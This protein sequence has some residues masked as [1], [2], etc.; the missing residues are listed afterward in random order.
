[1][2]LEKVKQYFDALGLGQRIHVL[3]Q[4]SATVEEAAVA[5]GCEP[6]RI[7]KTMSFLLGDDPIL[8]VTAGDARV[9]N[10]KYKE[11]FHQKAKMI[12]GELVEKYIGHAPGGVCPFAIPQGTKVFLDISLKRFA[13]VY[14]AAGTSNSAIELSIKELEDSSA[15]TAWI[16]VCKGWQEE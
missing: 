3:D 9:D 4:S 13:I 2:S 12:P 10:K 5:V 6:E 7:A 14:P 8:I 15:Y 11:Y 1:M 16:D